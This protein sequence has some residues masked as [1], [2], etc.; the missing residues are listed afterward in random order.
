MQKNMIAGV[1][2]N[3]KFN[4]SKEKCL[5]NQLRLEEVPFDG[6]YFLQKDQAPCASPT[7]FCVAKKIMPFLCPAYSSAAL[8]QC[9]RPGLR[10]MFQASPS[11]FFLSCEHS[12]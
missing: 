5:S 8:D 10:E 6:H 7:N 12:N 9:D 3:L 11:V 2:S 4:Q 1:A